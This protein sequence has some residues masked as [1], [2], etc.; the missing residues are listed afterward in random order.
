MHPLSGAN[1]AT[2]RAVFRAGGPVAPEH[3]AMA[4]S[5]W[6]SAFCRQPFSLA[7]RLWSAMR[8]PSLEELPPPLF[9]LGHWRSGTTH[10]NQVLIEAGFGIVP[11]AATGLPWD[12]LLLARLTE[13][14]IAKRLPEKRFIDNMAV[15]PDSPQE[16]EIALANMSRLSFYHGIYF[17]SR[18]QQAV[19]EGIFFD[20]VSQVEIEQWKR[21]FAY[22]LRKLALHQ[23]KRLLIKNPVYTARFGLLADYM[24]RSKFIHIHRNPFDVFLSMRNFYAKL[25]PELAFQ[26][27]DPSQIDRLIVTTYDRMM[28]NLE[29]DQARL[30][31]GRLST[32][33]YED[34]SLEPIRELARVWDEQ[35]LSEWPDIGSFAQH[36][37]RF[38]AYLDSVKSFEKNKF[39][40]DVAAAE[41]VSHHLGHWFDKLGYERPDQAARRN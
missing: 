22:F 36:E 2:L 19:D 27:H 12:I 13:K 4:R 21:T 33:R 30:P 31:A 16:D 29:R 15:K 5:A 6:L 23:K 26:P 25:F 8:I 17:P 28:Q 1:L 39:I 34:F 14:E 7:E 18:L 10:L 24:P 11:P 38:L 35:N 9:I 20:N 40:K 3:R 37:S 32:I 41:F